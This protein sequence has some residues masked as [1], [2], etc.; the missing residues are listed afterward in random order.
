M[1]KGGLI[2]QT[3]NFIADLEGCIVIVKDVMYKILISS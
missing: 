3:S 2:D 1:C